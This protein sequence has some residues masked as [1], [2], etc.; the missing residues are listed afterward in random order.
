M[1]RFDSDRRVRACI[2]FVGG[3][4]VGASLVGALSMMTNA[5]NHNGLPLH[6][7]DRPNWYSIVIGRRS[8]ESVSAFLQL[9]AK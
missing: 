1:L 5:G 3:P 7:H 8:L 2:N 9:A 6:A 4:N